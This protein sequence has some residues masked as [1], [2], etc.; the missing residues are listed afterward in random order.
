MS[1]P[2]PPL[3]EAH[4][5]RDKAIAA[6]AVSKIE[7]RNEAWPIVLRLEGTLV[8][9]FPGDYERRLEV[10]SLFSAALF[11]LVEGN[12]IEDAEVRRIA[13]AIQHSHRGMIG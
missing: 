2:P 13:R 1:M 3:M 11:L 8:E 7:Q 4:A 10:A 12:G 6:A 5:I 9:L